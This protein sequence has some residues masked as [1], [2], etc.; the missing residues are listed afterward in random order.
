MKTDKVGL[1][2]ATDATWTEWL[3]A[4]VVH[5]CR[6]GS[7]TSGGI[8]AFA[9]LLINPLGHNPAGEL[10][11]QLGAEF[12][13]EKAA[14][15]VTAVIG[16]WSCVYDGWRGAVFLIQLAMRLGSPNLFPALQ[17]LLRQ[18]VEMSS[19]AKAR[20]VWVALK[21]GQARLSFRDQQKLGAL[22]SQLHL[23]TP[24]SLA[25]YAVML[26]DDDLPLLPRRLLKTVP[27]VTI[28]PHTGEYAKPV[29]ER[30]QQEFSEDELRLAFLT[31]KYDENEDV[32]RIRMALKGELVL[33]DRSVSPVFETPQPLRALNLPESSSDELE[34]SKQFDCLFQD[35][36]GVDAD[37]GK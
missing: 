16:S 20:L 22:L 11:A 10:A 32:A 14:K 8:E 28:E 26:A 27:M 29:A 25:E 34:V 37:D 24:V 15:A 17:R 1:A 5:F 31:Q 13:T 18:S 36:D 2:S 4:A 7:A 23:W 9:P 19:E 12:R 6:P 21:A 30:L 35:L 3:R 33:S